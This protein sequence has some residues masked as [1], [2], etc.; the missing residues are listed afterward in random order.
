MHIFGIFKLFHNTLPLTAY[1]MLL[2][3]ISPTSKQNYNLFSVL[4]KYNK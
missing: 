1:V 2:Y 3:F 4:Q